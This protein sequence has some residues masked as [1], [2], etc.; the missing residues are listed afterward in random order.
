MTDVNYTV[1]LS[2]TE[3]Y[4]LSYVCYDQQEWIDNVVHERCRIAI[5]EVVK[6]VVE[7]CLELG[8]QIPSTREEIVALGFSS[9]YLTSAKK[10]QDDYIQSLQS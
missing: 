10:R 1:T 7:K 9:G 5:D 8:I 2:E 6:I 3:N 4:A